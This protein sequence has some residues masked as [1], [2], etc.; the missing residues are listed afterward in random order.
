[1]VVEEEEEL[2]RR[3]GAPRSRSSTWRPPCRSGR[4]R[5]TRCWSSGPSSCARGGSSWWGPTPRSSAPATSGSSPR[6]PCAA[7]ASPATPSPP[8]RPSA[9]SPTPST[10]S[11]TVRCENPLC[12]AWPPRDRRVS[13]PPHLGI[14]ALSFLP[15]NFILN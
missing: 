8:P 5:G 6:R 10:A 7:T 11:F 3:R 14:P 2:C 12:L 4:G 13:A 1:V 15:A 9:T